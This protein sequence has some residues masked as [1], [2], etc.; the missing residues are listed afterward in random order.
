MKETTNLNSQYVKFSKEW[1]LFFS[2]CKL[3]C[4]EGNVIRPVTW[5]VTEFYTKEW[6]LSKVGREK[7]EKCV[8]CQS[9]LCTLKITDCFNDNAS[10]LIVRMVF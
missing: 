2:K 3:S 1:E 4:Q 9:R 10:L 5:E 8:L 6:L 7:V